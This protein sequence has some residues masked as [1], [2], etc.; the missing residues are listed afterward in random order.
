MLRR[1]ELRILR[2]KATTRTAI[3]PL[4]PQP[5]GGTGVPHPSGEVGHSGPVQ[6]QAPARSSDHW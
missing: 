1:A 5:V 6:A 2:M 3:H 4:N